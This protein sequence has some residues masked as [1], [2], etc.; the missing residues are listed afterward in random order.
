MEDSPERMRATST[1]I[2][3]KLAYQISMPNAEFD[4]LD[5]FV[6]VTLVQGTAR[7]KMPVG[8]PNTPDPWAQKLVYIEK[9]TWQAKPDGPDRMI[10]TFTLNVLDW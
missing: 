10:V 8:R 6:V 9:G 2:W 1:A 5:T 4:T 7:F 3:S